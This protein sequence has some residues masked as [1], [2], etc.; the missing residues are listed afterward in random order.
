MDA[1]VGLNLAVGVGTTLDGE[2]SLR[3]SNVSTGTS[4]YSIMRL[5][6]SGGLDGV[7]FLNSTARTTDGGT[8][9]MTI[10]KDAGS[11]RLQTTSAGSSTII[12]NSSGI[13]TLDNA[14]ASTSSSTGALVLSLGGLAIGNTTDS[15]SAT[16]GGGGTVA[17]GFAIAKTLRVG[18]AAY[19]R[20]G[21]WTS[22]GD[23]VFINANGGNAIALRPTA[24][25]ANNEVYNNTVAFNIANS[26]G[27]IFA[28]FNHA[29]EILNLTG[30]GNTTAATGSF[31]GVE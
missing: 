17:G 15:V 26:T 22:N 10:R 28:S 6:N 1:Y 21:S 16:N 20:N 14:T 8:N 18:I 4:A 29:N 12:L 5:Q 30:T 3:I 2:R 13:T 25:S 19:I 27:T 9:T 7:I 31:R 23:D 11:L 24:G